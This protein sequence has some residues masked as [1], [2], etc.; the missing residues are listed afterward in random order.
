MIEHTIGSLT[1]GISI[2]RR[3]LD[4]NPVSTIYIVRQHTLLMIGNLVIKQQSLWTELDGGNIVTAD[5][6]QIALLIVSELAILLWADEVRC[7]L[8]VAL[9]L[10]QETSSE[11]QETDQL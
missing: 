9:T 4:I 7:G 2:G 5:V 11:Q 8:T 1:L 3:F 6:E 10:N